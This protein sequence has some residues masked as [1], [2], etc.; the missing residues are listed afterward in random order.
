MTELFNHDKQCLCLF[1]R[2]NAQPDIDTRILELLKKHWFDYIDAEH[3][4]KGNNGDR[5][6]H[7]DEEAHQTIKDLIAEQVAAAREEGLKLE[8]SRNLVQVGM[9]QQEL[10]GIKNALRVLADVTK[11]GT[12]E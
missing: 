8:Q 10:S 1:C 12:N 11:E 6:R 9:L 3:K 2:Q 7:A 4:V 5:L